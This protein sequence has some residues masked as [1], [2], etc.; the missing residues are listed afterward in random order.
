MGA[1]ELLADLHGSG[2]TVDCDGDG[3]VIRPASKL[4][5]DMRAALIAAKAD[6]LALLATQQRPYA[7]TDAESA[8]C[9]AEPWDDADIARFVAR[10]SQFLRTGIR[11][12][13]ADDLA[14]RLHLRDVELDSRTMCVECSHFRTQRCGN[15][16]SAGLASADVGRDFVSRLQRCSAFTCFWTSGGTGRDIGSVV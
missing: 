2:L 8:R 4:T 12:T 16:V 15:H 11:A 14:E 5:D 1:R 13:D 9:H 3:L 7:L 10:V 6:V